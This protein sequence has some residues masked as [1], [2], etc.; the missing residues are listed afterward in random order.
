MSTDDGLSDGPTRAAEYEPR[1]VN[2]S[3][4]PIGNATEG[5]GETD[6]RLALKEAEGQ[7]E[8]DVNGGEQIS[9]EHVSNAHWGA[10]R[11]LVSFVLYHP[12]VDP[13][14]GINLSQVE[15]YGSEAL[16]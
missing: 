15:E 4:V 8:T 9:D 7:L 11:N 1:Y 10:V 2:I 13:R 5:I 14:G 16:G 3:D 6:K 12:A